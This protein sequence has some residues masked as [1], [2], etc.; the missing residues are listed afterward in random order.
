VPFQVRSKFV[1]VEDVEEFSK[2]KKVKSTAGLS[3]ARLSEAKTKAGILS[4]LGET[5]MPKD[6]GGENNDIFTD[7]VTIGGKRIRGAFALTRVRYEW[8]VA[9]TR[10]WMRLAAPL[11]RPVFAWNHNTVMRWGEDGLARW[12]AAR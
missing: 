5:K 3:P 9:V 10:P 11:L 8:I 12:L 1:R 7:R 2:V 6:W 4:L